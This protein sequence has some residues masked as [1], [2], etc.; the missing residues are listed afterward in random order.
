MLQYA[1]RRACGTS[2]KRGRL[3]RWS[4]AASAHCRPL[5][6]GPAASDLR[7]PN[8]SPTVSTQTKQ[9]PQE[10]GGI[11]GLRASGVGLEGEEPILSRT[12]TTLGREVAR[13][14]RSD[15]DM[16]QPEVTVV[17]L[18][19]LTVVCPIID[20]VDDLGTN[21]IGG[22]VAASRVCCTTTVLWSRVM[23]RLSLWRV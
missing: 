10:D 23:L 21:S 2:L 16:L 22:M 12:S 17:H 8:P 6:S 7:C 1:A 15:R 19:L 20:S 11:R 14:V 4:A 3:C 9:L 5:S 18:L 13:I